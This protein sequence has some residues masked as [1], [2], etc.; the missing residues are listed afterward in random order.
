MKDI[1]S[2][3][4][5]Q[6][7]YILVLFVFV[8]M[9]VVMTYKIIVFPKYVVVGMASSPAKPQN[10]ISVVYF[11]N[12][13]RHPLEDLMVVKKQLQNFYTIGLLTLSTFHIVISAPMSYHHQ[14]R[15]EIS[16]LFSPT[17]PVVF[18]MNHED[19]HEYPSAQL[20]YYIAQSNGSFNHYILYFHAE[21]IHNKWR[22]KNIGETHSKLHKSVIVPWKRILN[23]FEKHPYVDKIGFCSSKSGFMWFNYWWVRASYIACLEPP[24]KIPQSDY[25]EQWLSRVLKNP[26]QNEYE[27]NSRNCWSL[28]LGDKMNTNK[29]RKSGY[30]YMEAVHFL[31]KA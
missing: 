25:Y 22:R 12:L 31:L 19:C 14:I 27:F 26:Y 20:I 11:A 10:T 30:E 18:H 28:C 7:T 8:I 1:L 6:H 21:D 17:D 29:N 4:I 13:F 9:L 24:M 3:R 2:S 5:L 15:Q 23:I 16:S